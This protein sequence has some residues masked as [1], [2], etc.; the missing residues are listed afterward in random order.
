VND[1]HIT[2]VGNVVDEPR[3]RTTN[4][5]GVPVLSFRVA[6]TARRINRE[7]GK[8]EDG[9]RLFATVTCWR[10]LAQNVARSLKKGQPVVVTGRFYSREYTAKDETSRAS[11]EVDAIA[12]G[13]DLSR[14]VSEFTKLSRPVAVTTVGL[15]PDGMP[16]DLTDERFDAAPAPESALAAVS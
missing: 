2:I 9:D 15:G 14:G 6:S 8:W 10:A 13:H 11:Y 5:S 1:T 3:L 12:I 7:S 4:S 16:A